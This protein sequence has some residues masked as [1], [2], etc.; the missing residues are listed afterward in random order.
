MFKE[1]YPRRKKELLEDPKVNSNNRKV[2]KKF[3][4]Y[5]EYKTVHLSY[6]LHLQIAQ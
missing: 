4:E 5:G 3:F 1:R 6:L 2:I